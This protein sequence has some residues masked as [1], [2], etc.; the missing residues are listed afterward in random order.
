MKIMT[1]IHNGIHESLL[2][3]TQELDLTELLTTDGI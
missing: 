1:V 3:L 2:F